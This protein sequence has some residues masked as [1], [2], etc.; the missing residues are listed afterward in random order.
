MRSSASFVACAS[1]GQ[2]RAVAPQ[3]WTSEPVPKAR[4]TRLLLSVPA[5]A[6]AMV[7]AG[8]A[9]S[10]RWSPAAVDSLDRSESLSGVGALGRLRPEAWAVA[11]W[12]CPG[13][14]GLG[15]QEGWHGPPGHCRALGRCPGRWDW[16]SISWPTVFGRLLPSRELA[17]VSTRSLGESVSSDVH[18]S[19]P[20]VQT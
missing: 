12:S 20:Q 17:M 14:A 8:A 7:C 2:G 4:L 18:F 15:G 6:R 19:P 5:A 3:A 9:S 11:V 16:V 10:L 13:V 1:E